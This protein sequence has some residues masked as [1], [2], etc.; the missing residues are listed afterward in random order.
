MHVH[1]SISA[2]YLALGTL[3]SFRFP[4]QHQ[5]TTKPD[6]TPSIPLRAGLF[7]PLVPRN[8]D[9]V[10]VPALDSLK[11]AWGLKLLCQRMGV[12]AVSWLWEW[13]RLVG[14]GSRKGAGVGL[15]VSVGLEIRLG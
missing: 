11:W 14:T 13:Q 15:R 10:G 3:I 1:L 12:S 8:S 6:L 7:I 2:P 9:Q 4:L 5:A